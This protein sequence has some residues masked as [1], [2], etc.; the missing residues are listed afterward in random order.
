MN[1]KKVNVV[2]VVNVKQ[3]LFPYKLE[4]QGAGCPLY[5][6]PCKKQIVHKWA[7]ANHF[8]LKAFAFQDFFVTLPLVMEAVE[9]QISSVL[10]DIKQKGYSSVQPFQQI[11][12]FLK[13]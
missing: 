1:R 10:E 8:S 5:P 6:V 13:Q 12:Y 7:S 9:A 11:I 3:K 4:M 2:Y